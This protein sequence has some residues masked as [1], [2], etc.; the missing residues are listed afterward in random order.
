[1]KI[2]YLKYFVTIYLVVASCR[3]F[4]I[5]ESVKWYAAPAGATRLASV[6]DVIICS[7]NI[8]NSWLVLAA[9]SGTVSCRKMMDYLW[10]TRAS[11][12]KP[13]LIVTDSRRFL[14]EVSGTKDHSV[15]FWKELWQIIIKFV[16]CVIILFQIGESNLIIFT[17]LITVLAYLLIL[18]V[19]MMA[20]ER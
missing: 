10:N 13:V 4:L 1:M 9:V 15:Y 12:R 16:I 7:Q 20:G 8:L 14:L 17:N 2:Y 11:A 19:L 18:L 6:S 5:I 3:R